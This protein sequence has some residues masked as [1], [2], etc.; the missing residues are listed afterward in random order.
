MGIELISDIRAENRNG[1]RVS[2]FTTSCEAEDLE[3]KLNF[4]IETDSNISNS[5]IPIKT[6]YGSEVELKRVLSFNGV[7]PNISDVVEA[8][9]S[10][11]IQITSDKFLDINDGNTT[12][13]TILNLTRNYS[14]P[15]NPVTITFNS[16]D[17]NSS[18]ISKLQDNNFTASG[19]SNIGVSKILYYATIA[20]DRENY[21]D[22]FEGYIKTPINA[23]IYCK[24][25]ITW[26]SQKIGANGLNSVQTINGWYRAINHDSNIDG[27]V[28]S[29][30]ISNSLSQVN[31]TAN[32]LPNF[33][34]GVAG[35]IDDIVTGYGGNSYPSEV[36]V[37]LDVS[38]W[39]K[40][41]KDPTRN[42]IAFWKVTFRDKN[43]TLSGVGESGNRLDI[44]TTTRPSKK[45]S[46]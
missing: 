32:N 23:F 17:L 25:T 43:G 12:L 28:N 40:Y 44:K 1:D 41:H 45:I 38:S 10:Q 3:I 35:R 7:I 37:D 20:P 2:N 31:P 21:G 8:N 42:G 16:L 14:E 33:K 26:C 6:I 15:I 30:I 13:S 27:K 5:D 29:F 9:L 19:V 46:W 36:I 22:E 4:N 39:L 24:R 34:D 11:K 18:S